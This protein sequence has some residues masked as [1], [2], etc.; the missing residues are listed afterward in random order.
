MQL[1]AEVV[2]T[3]A[4]ARS[5]RARAAPRAVVCYTGD[6]YDDGHRAG[7][8]TGAGRVRAIVGQRGA[9][10]FLRRRSVLLVLDD[11]EHLLATCARLLDDLLKRCAFL[12]ARATSREHLAVEGERIWRVPPLQVPEPGGPAPTVRSRGC[13]AVRGARKG[14]GDRFVID[15]SNI[16]VV[17]EICRRLDGIPLAVSL[18]PPAFATWIQ[19]RFARVSKTASD[20]PQLGRA[21][22]CLGSRLSARPWTGSRPPELVRAAFL[23]APGCLRG[24]CLVRSD[25]M[26]VCRQRRDRM[27]C[28]IG[29]P[30]FACRQVARRDRRHLG[31]QPL[32]TPGDCPRVCAVEARSCRRAGIDAS[33]GT[34][35]GR[36]HRATGPAAAISDP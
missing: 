22:R 13:P 24:R 11:C 25:R 8:P 14:G 16:G 20:F 34:E 2:E 35:I 12:R 18:Q 27:R 6:R 5:S 36:R 1:A 15:E 17:A 9:V 4:T 19:S 28:G 33:I 32:S 7:T 29:S 30:H 26:G 21:P 31:R 10:D 3:N 23:R